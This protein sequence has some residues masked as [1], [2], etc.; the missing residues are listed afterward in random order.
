M[1]SLDKMNKV[2]EKYKMP[3]F[4]W[5]NKHWN[6]YQSPVLQVT[7]GP[8]GIASEPHRTCKEELIL[9]C[10]SCWRKKMES[11][12]VILWGYYNR[13]YQTKCGKEKKTTVATS[14]FWK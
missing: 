10:T 9:S 13:D 2:L 12:Q 5:I 14:S 7:V 1:E 3:E 6:N 8:E 11:H 4:E